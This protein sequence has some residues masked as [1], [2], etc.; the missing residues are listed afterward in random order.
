MKLEKINISELKQHPKNPKKHEQEKI[1][2][3]YE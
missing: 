1:A 3:R 2:Q